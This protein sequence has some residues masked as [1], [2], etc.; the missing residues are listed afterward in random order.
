MVVRGI[1]DWSHRAAVHEKSPA[2]RL[3]DNGVFRSQSFGIRRQELLVFANK[4][5]CEG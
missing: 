2:V 1:F 4:F 5:G 3:F